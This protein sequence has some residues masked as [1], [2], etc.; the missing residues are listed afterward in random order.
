[1]A[2]LSINKIGGRLSEEVC[3]WGMTSYAESPSLLIPFTLCFLD[4]T[5]RATL[6]HPCS[7]T[8]GILAGASQLWT[9][10]SKI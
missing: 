5:T 7:F 1:M 9:K 2:A 4:A 10:I 6:L 8:M 3:H